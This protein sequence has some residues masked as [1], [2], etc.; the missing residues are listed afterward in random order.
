[1]ILT[2]LWL[3]NKVKGINE[4]K[5]R[6]YHEIVHFYTPNGNGATNLSSIFFMPDVHA[7]YSME[8]HGL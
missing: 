6:F 8:N 7:V 1:M 4:I 5:A 3:W 2:N